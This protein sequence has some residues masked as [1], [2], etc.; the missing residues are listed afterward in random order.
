MSIIKYDIVII[1][2]GSGGK[3]AKYATDEGYS[4]AIINT[5]PIGG[6]CW[7]FGCVPSKMLIRPAEMIMEIDHARRLGIRANIEEVDFEH[8]MTRM[9]ENREEGRN[10]SKKQIESNSY[11]DYFVGEGH[12]IDEHT[13]EV[14]DER[15]RGEKIFIANGARPFIPPIDGLEKIDYLTNETVLELKK[16]PKSV[17]IVGGGYIGVEYEHF[18]S[19]MGT[20]VTIIQRG[21][22]L[23]PREEPEIAELLQKKISERANVMLNFSS[24]KITQVDGDIIVEGVFRDRGETASTAAEKIMIATGRQS[25]ADTLDLDKAGIETTDRGYVAVD[26]YLR[27][28]IPHIWAIGDATGK[29]MFKHTANREARYAWFNATHDVQKSIDYNANPYAV[30]SYPEIAGVGMSEQEAREKHKTLVGRGNYRDVAMGVAMEQNYGFTKA[31]VDAESMKILGFR[32]IGSHASIMIQEI[33]N[34]IALGNTVD[35]VL[36]GMT[37]H[38]ALNEVVVKALLEARKQK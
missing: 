29:Y 18:F 34:A 28:N 23:M 3:I 16:R 7:N 5:P 30:F 1:G 17:I 31:I 26:E 8:L 6:T 9:R 37:V 25:N 38:P 2:D 14:N 20:E 33:T 36:A 21:D 15:I 24:K 4:T 19:A 27:T 32:I 13:I 10:Q 12:F 11:L 35:D 22:R